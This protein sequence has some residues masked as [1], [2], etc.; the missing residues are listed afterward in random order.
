MADYKP[1]S[2]YR[3]TNTIDNKF[4]DTLSIDDIDID[5]TT[6]RSVKL[7]LK[8]NQKP[9]LLAFELYGNAK[10]WWV[11]AIFNQNK[12]KDPIIDFK[13]GITIKVPVRFS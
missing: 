6:T 13:E 10:L 3:N 7:E 4:L 9:D 2:L 8:H 11:F 1:D 12:L 5:N